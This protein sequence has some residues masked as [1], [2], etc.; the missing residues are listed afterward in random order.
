MEVRKKNDTLFSG[1]TECCKQISLIIPP[2]KRNSNI[3]SSYYNSQID[4]GEFKISP[5]LNIFEMWLVK[6]QFIKSIHV[7]D[8]LTLNERF[9]DYY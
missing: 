3:F 4:I 2:Q 5:Y 1:R 7:N 8:T 6:L 9:K